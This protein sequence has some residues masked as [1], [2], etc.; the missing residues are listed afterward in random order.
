MFS[1]NNNRA[2]QS[3]NG[4]A[5]QPISISLSSL[6]RSHLCTLRAH[7]DTRGSDL[8]HSHASQNSKFGQRFPPSRPLAARGGSRSR[9]CVIRLS[10][11]PHQHHVARA[12]ATTAP[13]RRYSATQH[14]GALR[15]RHPSLP[16]R[17]PPSIVPSAHLALLDSVLSR[18]RPNFCDV[19]QPC[20]PTRP[21]SF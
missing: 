12:A 20:G 16:R 11:R 2:K 1:Q 5:K 4:R 18:H 6:S 3:T 7:H 14:R 8:A 15:V 9:R 21:F 17:P 13:G 19:Y 10:V